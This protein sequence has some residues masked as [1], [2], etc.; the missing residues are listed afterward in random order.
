[1]TRGQERFLAWHPRSF[2][3]SPRRPCYYLEDRTTGFD[4][5]GLELDWV[6]ICWDAD[7]R[8]VDAQWSDHKFRGT[9][10]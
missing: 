9:V 1:M 4:I 10:W 8:G 2:A 6:G 7:F 3:S 5:Q